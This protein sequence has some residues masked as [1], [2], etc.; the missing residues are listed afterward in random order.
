MLEVFYITVTIIFNY[1]IKNCTK[2]YKFFK[3]SFKSVK[4]PK[5]SESLTIRGKDL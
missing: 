5:Y 4:D 1:L 2:P 3:Y